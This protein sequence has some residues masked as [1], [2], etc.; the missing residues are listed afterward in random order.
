MKRCFN[1]NGHLM[2][3]FGPILLKLIL[4]LYYVLKVW[5]EIFCFTNK[6]EVLL[7]QKD[8]V[9]TAIEGL[10]TLMMFYGQR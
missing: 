2:N 5:Y 6:S 1:R 7:V 10:L 4:N 8:V 9:I 3:N